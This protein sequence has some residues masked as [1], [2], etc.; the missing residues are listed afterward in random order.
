MLLS[1]ITRSLC[2]GR[3]SYIVKILLLIFITYI[4]LSIASKGKKIHEA[5]T[6]P[7]FNYK[8][9][10]VT[11]NYDLLSTTSEYVSEYTEYHGFCVR[12]FLIRGDEAEQNRITLALHGSTS[13]LDLEYITKLMSNWR[14]PISFA[15]YLHE[16]ENDPTTVR[17]LFLSAMANVSDPEAT[18]HVNVHVLFN[19]YQNLSCHDTVSLRDTYLLEYDNSTA[20]FARYPINVV[21]NVARTY[22]LTHYQAMADIDFLFSARFEEKMRIIADQVISENPKAALVYRIFEIDEDAIASR[23]EAISKTDLRELYHSGRARTFHGDHWWEGHGIPQLTRWMEE[24]E[25]ELPGVLNITLSQKR[26]RPWEPQIIVNRNVPK[27]DETFPYRHGNNIE[28]RWEMCRAGYE[29]RL[30][31]DLFVYHRVVSESH[32]DV[33]TVK[34]SIS[35]DNYYRYRRAVIEFKQ[36]MARMYPR[37]RQFCPI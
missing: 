10:E 25:K 16:L 2:N 8:S 32:R 7:L 27:F 23:T 12:P 13:A 14:A 15:I 4:S 17:E 29:L 3:K 6:D 22:I 28:L 19:K 24:P 34:D 11:F 33:Q 26:R 37:T 35:D 20:Y 36:R 31:E 5:F 18:R 1:S 30:V 9:E 21:R